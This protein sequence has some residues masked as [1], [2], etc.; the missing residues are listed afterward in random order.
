MKKKWT[1]I[2]ISICAAAVLLA[3]G[4]KAALEQRSTGS[5]GVIGAADGPTAI[6][7]TYRVDNTLPIVLGVAVV[8]LI[9]VL[10]V[11]YYRKMHKT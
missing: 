5:I 6:F 7:V 9:A 1:V 10:C 4:I 3:L 11:L 2:F 8:F